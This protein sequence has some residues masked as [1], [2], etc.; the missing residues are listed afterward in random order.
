MLY[1]LFPFGQSQFYGNLAVRGLYGLY[2]AEK[3]LDWTA[4]TTETKADQM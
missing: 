3:Q 2:P 1:M 4:R